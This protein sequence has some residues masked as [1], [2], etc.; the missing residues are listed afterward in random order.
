MTSSV[1]LGMPTMTFPITAGINLFGALED[2]LRHYRFSTADQTRS[3][4]M[5]SQTSVPR[6]VRQ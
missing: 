6:A 3:E 5:E 2:N 4:R 1:R